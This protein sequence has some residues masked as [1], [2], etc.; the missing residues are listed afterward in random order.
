MNA[1]EVR[2]VCAALLG[3]SFEQRVEQPCIGAD[4]AGD[5]LRSVLAH[6]AV[7]ALDDQR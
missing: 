3:M 2:D 1:G 4:Q 5:F 6:E 7:H